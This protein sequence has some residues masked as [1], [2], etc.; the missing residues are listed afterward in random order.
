[1]AALAARASFTLTFD[2]NGLPVRFALTTG[3][4]LDN[5]LVLALLAGPE[6]GSDVAC[7][8]VDRG[9]DAEWIRTHC[10]AHGQTS[11]RNE[12]GETGPSTV[13]TIQSSCS[14]TRLSNIAVSQSLL[15]T[16][17]NYL[18]VIQLAAIRLRSRINE[19]HT[20]VELSGELVMLLM[21]ITFWS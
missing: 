5:C 18:A 21:E 14:S 17:G 2:S 4:A 11:H 15:Q 19:V 1:M 7:G 9:Y 10:T 13:L 20:L 3:K 16:A 8:S 12:P 6:I